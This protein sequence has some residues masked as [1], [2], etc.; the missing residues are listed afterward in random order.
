MC[1]FKLKNPNV[2]NTVGGSASV[3]NLFYSDLKK[4]CKMS[5]KK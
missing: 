2:K 5:I 1:L 3:I 4:I